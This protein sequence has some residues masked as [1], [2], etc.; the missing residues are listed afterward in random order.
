MLR[1]L[2]ELFRSFRR[3]RD[4]AALAEV[5]DRAAPELLRVACHVASDLAAAEDLV[6]ATFLTAIES[7]ARWDERRALLPWLLGIL[8]N[9]ARAARRASE[10]RPE[11]R[12]LPGL[13]PPAAARAQAREL[14]SLIQR[15]LEELAEPY[16]EVAIL[17]LRHELK[18]QEIAQA[19]GRSPGAVR[20]QLHR[21]LETLRRRLPRD[22]ALSG[23]LLAGF[24][25]GL[26]P[27]RAVVLKS[28]AQVAAAG[29]VVTVGSLVVTKKLVVGSVVAL[30]AASILFVRGLPDSW[31]RT[32][33]AA[34]SETDA[35]ARAGDRDTRDRPNSNAGSPP[36]HET[37]TSAQRTARDEGRAPESST[38]SLSGAVLDGEAQRP[39]AD[40]SVEFFAPARMTL[41]EVK[42]RFSELMQKECS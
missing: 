18:P 15:A 35:P 36:S 42:T 40:A 8:A 5:F 16:R 32:S 22:A 38:V 10:R 4:P 7:E 39:L 33:H 17:S 27:V 30:A 24:G 21:A 29:A 6:Q 13:A 9:H 34:A 41:R 31:K 11:L 2:E 12:L 28:A 25:R 37:P 23:F 20:V 19:L 1:S 26:G 14:D 3:A